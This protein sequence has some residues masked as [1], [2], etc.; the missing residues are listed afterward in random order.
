MLAVCWGKLVDGTWP[1]ISQTKRLTQSVS[2][3][4]TY[5]IANS[6]ARELVSSPRR[7][8]TSMTSSGERNFDFSGLS[9]RNQNALVPVERSIPCFCHSHELHSSIPT[10]VVKM[11]SRMKIHR[12]DAWPAIPSD[13]R[14]MLVRY[15]CCHE[16]PL[17]DEIVFWSGETAALAERHHTHWSVR[18]AS[19][20]QLLGLP[21]W[22]PSKR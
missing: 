4:Q 18:L 14:L 1:C 17:F 19:C 9:Y 3:C 5:F 13:D 7:R 22:L 6:S 15:S 10:S 12:H 11:P 2:A 8:L 21:T 20:I 16:M